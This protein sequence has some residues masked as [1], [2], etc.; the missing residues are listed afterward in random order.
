MSHDT[1]TPDIDIMSAFAQ[2]NEDL[3]GEKF[4]AEVMMKSHQ[5]KM[6]LIT[7]L[8]LLIFSAAV[9]AWFFSFPLQSSIVSI[10]ELLA[11]PLLSFSGSSLEWLFSPINNFAT[12]VLILVKGLRSGYTRFL[13]SSG[14][15]W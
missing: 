2:A 10:S 14:P 9:I 4:T 3:D 1:D 12:L 15:R 7:S 5:L 13:P 6:R 11:T 8:G